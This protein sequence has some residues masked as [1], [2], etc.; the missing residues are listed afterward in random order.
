[1]QTTK[2][3][4]HFTALTYA[5]SLPT[6]SIIIIIIIPSQQLPGSQ[7]STCLT[8]QALLVHRSAKN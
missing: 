1:M 7:N 2:R 5:S 3:L 4:T 8:D 6:T